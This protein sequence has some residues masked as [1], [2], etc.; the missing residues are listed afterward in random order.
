M[1]HDRAPGAVGLAGQLHRRRQLRALV[2]ST[3][4]DALSLPKLLEALGPGSARVKTF[5]MR[6]KAGAPDIDEIQITLSRLTEVQFN[7]VTKRLGDLPGV[8]EIK[9]ARSRPDV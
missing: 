9:E 7:A 5:V 4:R 2:I 3:D 8:L 6:H 1:G